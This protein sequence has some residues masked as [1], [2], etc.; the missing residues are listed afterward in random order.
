MTEPGRPAHHLRVPRP[1]A[2]ALLA[3]GLAACGSSDPAGPDAAPPDAAIDAPDLPFAGVYDDVGDFPRT[4]CVPGALAGFAPTAFYPSLRVRLAPDGAGLAAFVSFRALG[5]MPMPILHRT[6]DDLLLRYASDEGGVWAVHV[7]ATGAG[8]TLRGTHAYCGRVG[9]CEVVPLAARPL[10]RGLGESE[11]RGLALLGET[12]GTPAWPGITVNVRVDGDLAVLARGE[13]G[14]RLVDVADPAAPVERAHHAVSP[15]SFVNDVKVVRAGDRRY[16]ITAA[17]PCQVLDVTDPARP[18]LAA[19]LPLSAH[20]VFV[21]GTR[22]YFAPGTVGGPVAVFD[23]TDPRL[24]R[25]LG[26]YQ[27]GAAGLVHDLYV[28][29]QVA[30]LSG[31]GDGLAIVDLSDPILP[32]VVGIEQPDDGRFWHSP[33]L[34]RI[35]GHPYVVH[36]DEGVNTGLRVL[37]ADPA[38]PTFLDNLGNW[39]SRAEVSLHNVMA[40]GARAYVSHYRDGIRVFDLTTPTSPTLVGYFNTWRDGTGTAAFYD[41]AFGLDLDPARRRIYVADSYRGL[42]VLQGDATI[43]P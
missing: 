2:A 41:G 15:S 27:L 8:G 28:E 38:S 1:R 37:D 3:L 25:R 26:Q 21:E 16:V 29:D 43:F 19:E 17:S 7:C 4:A 39:P 35:D 10:V 33:W 32:V 14:V 13:D 11:G 30:Y 42:L 6:D 20:T 9:P 23:V 34:T 5:E 24:P 12:R 36:G 31:G 18:V 22:A 40:L